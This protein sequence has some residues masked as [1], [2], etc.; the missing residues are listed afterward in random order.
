MIKSGL[1]DPKDIGT[2]DIATWVR[3]LADEGK[4]ARSQARM[5]VAVRGFF[6]HLLRTR[7]LEQDPA[8]QVELPRAGKTL[9][10]MV[11]Y[12]D[13]LALL[14]AAKSSA[15]DRALIFLLY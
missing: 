13:V 6:R 8:R 5:L 10:K 3:G 2:E 1:T 12:E 4:K 11:G 14:E 9:P 15:R 7:E